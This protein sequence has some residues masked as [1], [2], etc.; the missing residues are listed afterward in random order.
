M[1]AISIPD[2]RAFERT[3]PYGKPAPFAEPKRKLPGSKNIP[4]GL[5]AHG[6]R[7]LETR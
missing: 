7:F 6:M 3:I 1:A 2:T 4:E 5:L